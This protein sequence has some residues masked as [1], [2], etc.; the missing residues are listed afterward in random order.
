VLAGGKSSRM[1]RDKA[2]L[3]FAGEPLLRRVVERLGRATGQVLVIGPA[4]LGALVPRVQVVPDLEVGRGPLGGLVTA[5][6]TADANRVFVVGC[7]MPFVQ[8]ALVAAMIERARAELTLDAVVLRSDRGAEPL[9]AVYSHRCLLAAVDQLARGDRSLRHLLR[10][11]RVG[12]IGP[13]EAV[14]YD[15]HGLSSY[16]VNSP[17]DWAHAVTLADV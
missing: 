16:N 15:P 11:L 9:H 3:L 8:P 13:E 1:G 14:R 2:S 6:R 4:E 5:L 17:E 12:E 10:R 7:D